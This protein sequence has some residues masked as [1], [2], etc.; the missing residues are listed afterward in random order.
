MDPKGR[1]RQQGTRRMTTEAK[2]SVYLSELVLENVKPFKGCHNLDLTDENGVPAPWTLILGDNGVGKTTLLQCIA[3]MAPTLNVV[4]TE[5]ISITESS[6]DTEEVS[7]VEPWAAPDNATTERYARRGDV[8]VE[9][10][11]GFVADCALG[12]PSNSQLKFTTWIK[13]NRR[14]GKTAEFE[15]A[16]LTPAPI[17]EEPL[18]LGYGAGRH[19]QPGNFDQADMPGATESVF[20]GSSTLLDVEELLQY[21]DYAALKSDVKKTK[22]EPS[23]AQRK[24]DIVLKMIAALLPD[25]AKPSHIKVY[26]PRTAGQKS[27]VWFVTP[28]GEVSFSELSFGYQTMTAWLCDIAWRLFQKYPDSEDPLREPAIVLVDEIDLHL[29]PVW[30]R[31][32]RQRLIESFPAVQF[33]ATAHSPLMAQAS[34]DANLAVVKRVEDTVEIINDPHVVRTWRLDQVI[35]SELFGLPTGWSPYVDVLFEEKRSLV[36][37]D[38]RTRADEDRLKELNE[39]IFGLQTETDANEEAMNIIRRAAAALKDPHSK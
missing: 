2:R 17:E 38:D 20:E 34:I 29:H 27:G 8:H 25:V 37:K 21:L 10:R 7:A 39:E 30:Q 13:F 9:M 24:Y 36:E 3:F 35:T 12:R 6:I 22:S 1:A 26:G 32:I 23:K 11:G 5:L 15:V 31:E 16:S 4:P 19:M 28:Y 14:E 33:I 18:V